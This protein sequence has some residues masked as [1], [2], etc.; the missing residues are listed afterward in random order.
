MVR[1]NN[2]RSIQGYFVLIGNE[3]KTI[4]FAIRYFAVF[5]SFFLFVL[6]KFC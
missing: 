4:F 3:K 6:A 1:V 2:L 5:F